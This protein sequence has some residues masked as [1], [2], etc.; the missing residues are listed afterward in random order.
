MLEEVIDWVMVLLPWR[1]WL[2]LMVTL[3]VL[4]GLLVLWAT[5]S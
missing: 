2:A 5:W 1:A 3:A 4:V